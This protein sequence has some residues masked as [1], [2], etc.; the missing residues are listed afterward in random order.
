MAGLDSIAQASGR[1]NR[2]GEGVIKNTYIIDLEEE[3]LGSLEDIKLGKDCTVN[4]LDEYRRNA[5]IFDNNL[6][7]PKAIQRYYT[8]FYNE[9]V[10]ENKLFSETRKNIVIS[11]GMSVYSASLGTSGEC[12]VVKFHKCKDGISLKGKKRTL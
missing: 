5:E 11:R 4:V 3:T 1:G 10:I 8:Y 6:L 12:D 2:N 9:G 7:S